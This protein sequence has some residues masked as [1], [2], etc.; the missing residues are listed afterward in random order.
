MVYPDGKIVK[1]ENIHLL[2]MGF[3]N[4]LLIVVLSPVYNIIIEKNWSCQALFSSM[5]HYFSL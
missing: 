2:P 5:R 3:I 1:N 4:V